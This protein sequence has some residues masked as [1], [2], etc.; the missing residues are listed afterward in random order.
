MSPALQEDSL[1]SEPP[2]KPEGYQGEGKT[3][4]FGPSIKYKLGLSCGSGN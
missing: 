1:L 4:F 2:G 3:N